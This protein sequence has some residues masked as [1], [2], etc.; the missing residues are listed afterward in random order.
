MDA[1]AA[2]SGV[3]YAGGGFLT[4]GGQPREWLVAID[5]VTGIPTAWTPSPSGLVESIIPVGS[6]LYVGGSFDRI[7]GRA[8]PVL[9]ELDTVTG[10]AT[11]WN[12]RPNSEVKAI[13]VAGDR[14]YAGGRFTSLGGQKRRGIA[15]LDVSSGAISSW[16][17]DLD[18]GVSAL[19]LSGSTLYLAGDFTT[20]N[21][22]PRNNGA[23][24]DA[25]TGALLPWN[26]TFPGQPLGRVLGL[27]PSGSV[28]YAFDVF[29]FSRALD[30]I[31]G[32][33]T[34]WN[35]SVNGQVI[36]LAVAGSAVYIGGEFT[37]AGGELRRHIA[38]LDAV[39]GRATSWNPDASC[40]PLQFTPCFEALAVD[41]S[42][43]YVIGGFV[44]IGGQARTGL[45]ALDI[46]T[47]AATNWA[48]T[49]AISPGSL[50]VSGTTVYAA[51]LI[52]NGSAGQLGELVAIDTLSGTTSAFNPV[53]DNLLTKVVAASGLVV[54]MGDFSV[55]SGEA[56]TY[57]AVF[58][59]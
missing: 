39:T 34:A 14:V 33:A 51:G 23:A 13:H 25:P 2:S 22:Q 52:V 6:K 5:A 12:P 57:F 36:A 27:V 26:P 15:A 44:S 28:V 50:A 46:S 49:R 54:V 16:N 4:M 38:A 17:L 47:G 59:P 56:R 40:I 37:S 42:K 24:V 1:V 18:G 41:A 9:A 32:A 43:V 31:S 29:G 3:V 7:G 58:R 10:M 8:N 55:I 21:G 45:V 30:A 35:A 48:P 19:A 20:V 11:A 53:A